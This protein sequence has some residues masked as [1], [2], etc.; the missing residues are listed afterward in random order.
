[1]LLVFSNGVPHFTRMNFR[2]FLFALSLAACHILTACNP[3]F[4]WR[5]VNLLDD[6]AKILMPGK[7]DALN[8]AIVLNTMPVTMAMQGVKINETTFTV[9][10]AALPDKT[11]AAADRAIA[12]MRAQMIR[13]IAGGAEFIQPGMVRVIN[14]AGKEIATLAA[15]RIIVPG[16]AQGRPV[17]MSASFIQYK[18][19]VW[20]WLVITPVNNKDAKK[21]N[22]LSDAAEEFLTSFRL[23]DNK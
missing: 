21:D 11:P 14:D 20:Q 10:G 5:E 3:T 7:P 22:K 15:P 23:I 1:M 6:R 9:A 17:Q 2:P 12:G 16:T 13:N 4:N 19:Y 8:R 18:G